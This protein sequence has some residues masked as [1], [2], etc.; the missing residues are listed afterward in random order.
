MR[1]D[2]GNHPP[3]THT[4]ALRQAV[5]R[6]LVRSGPDDNDPEWRRRT[7]TLPRL[8]ALAQDFGINLTEDFLHRMLQEAAGGGCGQAAAAPAVTLEDFERVLACTCLY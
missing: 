1:V 2:A 3:K 6:E 4:P 7:L 5:F 8:S